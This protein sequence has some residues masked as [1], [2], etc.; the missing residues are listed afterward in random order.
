MYEFMIHQKI[1][2]PG[3]EPVSITANLLGSSERGD[4]LQVLRG[5]LGRREF[6]LHFHREWIT[7]RGGKPGRWP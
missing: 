5:A 1:P 4:A 3:S 7:A 6:G 2:M